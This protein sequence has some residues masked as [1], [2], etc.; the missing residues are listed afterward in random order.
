[1]LKDNFVDIYR[2]KEGTTV[3][4]VL[5][6]YKIGGLRKITQPSHSLEESHGAG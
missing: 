6:R 3:L 5:Q 1:M 2:I 4:E